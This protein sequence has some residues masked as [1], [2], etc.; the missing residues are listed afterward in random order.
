MKINTDKK[1]KLAADLRGL[2][3]IKSKNHL[4][5]SVFVCG[6]I[7]TFLIS[8]FYFAK[9]Q[10]GVLIPL[11]SEKPDA[12]ILALDV[13]NV[14]ITIDNQHA[15]VKIMQIFDNRAARSL[16]GK[17]V[18]ALPQKSSIS[19]F[20]VWDDDQRIPGVMME[21]RRANQIYE[22]V[23]QQQ[24]DPGILQTTDETTSA[25]GFSAKITPINAYRTKRLEMEYTEDLAIE[26]LRSHF[27][28]PLKPSYGE[29]QSVGEF[30]LKIRVLNDFQFAP[31]GQENPA[32]PLQIQKSEPNEF[33]G[34]FHA[35]DVELK[36]DFSFDYQINAQEN[37]LSVV[38]YRAPEQISAYDLRDPKLADKSAD[39]FFQASAIFAR[40]KD[41]TRQPKRVV[42]ALDTSLS[43]YGDKLARAVEAV[44]YFLHDLTAG[45]E[46]N[47]VLF[48]DEADVFAANPVPATAVNV[49]EA[50]DFVKKSSFG[51]GTN[52]KRGL[53]TAVQQSKKLSGGEANI[54]LISDANPTLET[55]RTK[56]IERVFDHSNVRLF[57]FALGADT[58]ENLLKSLTEKTHGSFDAAR[59]TED[60]ALKLKL[61]LE[62]V[63]TP[64]V[65]N[66]DLNSSDGSNLYDVYASGENSF[67]GSNIS[68]VGR[69]K[70]PDAQNI[71]LSA[72]YGA[73]AIN[74]SREINLPEFDETH[75]FLPRVWARARVDALVQAMNRDG[76]R[77]D[78]IA[79]IIRLSEKYKF[80]TDYTAFIA[81]PRA[82]LRPRL[83]QPGDPVIRVKTDESIKEVF[84]VLP[85]G[86]T[87]P[88]KFLESE[89]VWETRFLAPVWMADGAYKCRLLL[90]D[91]NG[92]GYSEE[93]TFVVDSRAPKVKINLDKQTFR[94][95]E[96]INLKVSADAD[97]N[98]L[99]AKFYGAKPVQLF[100]SSEAKTNVGKLKIPDRLAS[101]KYVLSV[102]AED[103][104]HNQTNEDVQIE[105]LGK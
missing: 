94:A 101:G 17:Y 27:S 18:F 100:W 39:G 62:K 82:L 80:V 105:V 31:V 2:T 28:F 29:S 50:L 102:S 86:E 33:V 77:E 90:T 70:K 1:K 98:R 52:L 72:N 79:E 12:K 54:I 61:F 5:L 30:N 19:D 40:R 87:M 35:S 25:T 4:C 93:K 46:F 83:I 47:L 34:E 53:E 60:I 11:P 63:G 36:D 9:A 57:A 67:F 73:D 16:E 7:S 42:L 85:F 15:T 74:L 3:R 6:L 59:E 99:I 38:A 81:A 43:M 78:Y 96:E 75:S 22:A 84:A 55:V 97:T 26:N 20:A 48:S 76:E 49:E 58:N 13:M 95:G 104:A 89:G 103:F 64:D 88:L 92:A 32:Y 21:R 10:S 51:G 41:E 23:K 24:T 56:E 65:S 66:F 37:A 69:Y 68:F 8:P 45:D 71:N 91:K 44:D 14:E